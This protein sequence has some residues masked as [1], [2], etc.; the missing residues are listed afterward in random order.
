MQ[1]KN[2]AKERERGIASV[3]A[4]I[5][6]LRS[7]LPCLLLPHIISSYV[8]ISRAQELILSSFTR[9]RARVAILWRVTILSIGTSALILLLVG[10][11][12]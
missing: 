6:E 7:L 11:V 12:R 8:R 2:F 3:L 9:D 4:K 1:K 10:L 5:R